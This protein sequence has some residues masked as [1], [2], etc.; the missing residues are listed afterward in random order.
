[1]SALIDRRLL[2]KTGAY[3]LGALTLPGGAMAAMQ[4]A[5]RLG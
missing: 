4:G 5:R 2:L 1:M 3:G